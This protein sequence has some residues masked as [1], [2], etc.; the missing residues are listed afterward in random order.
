MYNNLFLCIFIVSGFFIPS[1]NSWISKLESM[2]ISKL[3]SIT[4]FGMACK[5]KMVFT[6]LNAS[7]KNKKI[8]AII[9]LRHVK[10]TCYL[11]FSVHNKVF[12]E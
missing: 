5:L 3:E 10:I 8:N 6:V 4:C 1:N 9:F 12:L 2:D 7:G 11:N